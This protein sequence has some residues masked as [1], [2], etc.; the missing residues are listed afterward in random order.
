V[1]ME[2]ADPGNGFRQQQEIPSRPTI[3]DDRLLDH[4]IE[5]VLAA[6]TEATSTPG[7]RSGDQRQQHDQAVATRAAP[8]AD[9]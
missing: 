7:E 4:H 1:R 6:F 3:E 8:T 9:I 2:E 5:E